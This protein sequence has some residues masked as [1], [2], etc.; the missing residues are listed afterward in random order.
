[1]LANSYR[2]GGSSSLT[3]GYTT[4]GNYPYIN[5]IEKY[6]FASSANS[7]DVGDISGSYGSTSGTS[8]TSYGFWAG[9]GPPNQNKIEKYSY[10][11]DGNSS[12][13]GDLTAARRD[14]GA[15]HV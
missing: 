9:G 3:H 15:Y 6:A 11:S 10:S 14:C 4:G 7:T 12:D 2:E 8:S 13:V 1:M 5:P